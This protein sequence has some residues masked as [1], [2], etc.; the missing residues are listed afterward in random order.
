MDSFFGIGSLELLVILLLAGILLG[1]Q[2]IRHVAKWL[3][4]TTAQLQGVARAFSRQLNAELDAVD[5]SG[6]VRDTMQELKNLRRE[7]TDLRRELT[8]VVAKPYAEASKTIK[9]A[10]ESGLGPDGGEN[11]IEPPRPTADAANPPSSPSLPRPLDVA[12]D[13]DT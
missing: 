4:R 13:P 5:G 11:R 2:R 10:Q 9:S 8:S 3:G 1:P 6:D 12:D 7:V